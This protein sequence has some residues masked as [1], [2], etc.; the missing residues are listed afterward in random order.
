[1]SEPTTA[2]PLTDAEIERLQTFLASLP[3]GAMNIEQMDGFFAGLLCAPQQVTAEVWMPLVWGEAALQSA[4]FEDQSQAQDLISLMMRH[5]N[6]MGASL[7]K[8]MA[9]GDDVHLPLLFEDDD[10]VVPA[11]DWARGFARAMQLSPDGWGELLDNEEEGGCLVPIMM[12]EH[13]HDE[14]PETR[15][16]EIEP[17]KRQ[18]LINYLVVGLNRAY[19]YFA[20]HRRAAA[21]ASRQGS[22][23]R[24]SAPK[25]GRNDPCPCGSG[26][27]FKLCCGRGGVET[28]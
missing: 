14:D 24:R 13:E 15:S 21:L 17:D 10:G 8:A 9:R 1:M 22:T 7:D 28:S 12:L 4:S 11:N 19:R 26:R 20:P 25:P 3:A 23:F 2:T 27:K 5:W 6:A 18:E 16:P